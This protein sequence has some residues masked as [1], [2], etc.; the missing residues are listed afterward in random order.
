MKPVPSR[1]AARTAAAITAAAA[2]ALL[3]ACSSSPSAAGSGGAPKAG[4]SAVSQ[5]GISYATC[6]RSHGVPKYPDPSSSNELPDG[7]PKVGLQQLDVSNAQYQAAQHACAHLLPNGGQPTQAQAQ[8]DLTAMRRFAR[9]MRSHGVPT[10]PDP[11]EDSAAGWGFN[12]LH[13]VG[14]DPSS[15]EIDNKMD[16]CDRALP[17]GIGVP[18]SRP[19]RPG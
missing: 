12:L 11:N 5:I 4:A 18:L 19:G 9:C 2:L 8:Q 7:L 10:W 13:V 15:T 1:P 16:E 17:P 3:A 14:F 6:M